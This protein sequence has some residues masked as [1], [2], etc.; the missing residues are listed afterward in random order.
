MWLSGTL[1]L[2][3]NL[4]DRQ[5]TAEKMAADLAGELKALQLQKDSLEQRNMQLEAAL[6]KSRADQSS[7]QPSDRPERPSLVRF[8]SSR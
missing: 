3:I 4:Q 5:E 1:R 2:E 7:A 6:L 8:T